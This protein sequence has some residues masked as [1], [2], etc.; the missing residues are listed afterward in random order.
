MTLQ[1]AIK[2][3]EGSEGYFIS[4]TTYEPKKKGKEL[5]HSYFT[6]HFPKGDLFSSL[7]EISK[8]LDKEKI[9]FSDTFKK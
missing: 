9:Q 7:D 8:L 3:A 2:K 1:E 4:I 6:K 5:E